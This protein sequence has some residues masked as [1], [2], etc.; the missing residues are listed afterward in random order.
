MSNAY[1]DRVRQLLHQAAHGD[2]FAPSSE[3]VAHVAGCAVCKGALLLMMAEVLNAQLDIEDPGCPQ[4]ERSLAAYL[5]LELERGS[6]AALR[7]YPQIAW[8]LWTCRNCAELYEFTRAVIEAEQAGTLSLPPPLVAA[9]RSPRVLASFRLTRALL[10]VSLS[11]D[12]ALGTARGPED[13][14]EV[15]YER[16]EAG[17]RISLSV[18]HLADRSWTIDVAVEPALEGRFRLTVGEFSREALFVAGNATIHGVSAT[19]LEEADGADLLG[20]LLS[21]PPSA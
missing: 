19:A 9:Q 15:L 7:V 20:E 5:D 21:D 13:G 4:C 10:N 8:H 12:R 16:T 14:P 6:A 2:S 1:C 17:L 3:L 18:T 11:S